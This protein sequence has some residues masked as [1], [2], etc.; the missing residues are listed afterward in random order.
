MS[1]R[2]IGKFRILIV[3]FSLAFCLTHT[4]CLEPCHGQLVDAIRNWF[5]DPLIHA[6]DKGLKPG[7]DLAWELSQL[8]QVTLATEAQGQAVL[9]ALASLS[10]DQGS[11]T[12][13]EN[14]VEYEV[15]NLFLY[16]W[17]VDS[18]AYI[19]LWRRG[20]PE[21]ISVYDKLRLRHD[22]ATRAGQPVDHE[23][24]DDL[25]VM[26]SVMAQFQTREGTDCVLEAAQSGLGATSYHW[27]SVLSQYDTEHP[28]SERLFSEF[29]K[30]LPQGEI[31]TQL[32]E[33]ANSNALNDA[34]FAHPFSSPAG[35]VRLKQWLSKD[36][37]STDVD[38]ELHEHARAVAI[39][40]AFVD[41]PERETVLEVAARHPDRL[42]RLEGAWAAARAGLDS[43]FQRLVEYT[44]D[45][46]SSFM[47]QAYLK[48]FDRGDLI[49]AEALEP[50]FAAM[51]ELSNWLQSEYEFGQAPDEMEV[52]DQRQLKWLPKEM[53][54][55]EDDNG[56]VEADLQ[57]DN[58]DASDKSD[59]TPSEDNVARISE[60]SLSNF[61]LL[62]VVRY[63]IAG[64]TPL[65]EDLTG[66]GLVGSPMTWSYSNDDLEQ[67]PVE[68]V[69]GAHYTLEAV[70]NGLIEELDWND[71]QQ[72]DPKLAESV[73]NQWTAQPPLTDLDV[74]EVYRLEKE[75]G[76]PQPRVYV[77]SARRADQPGYVVLA[78]EDSR[79]YPADQFPDQVATS[80]ILQLHIGRQLL[81]FPPAETRMLRPIPV[82]QIAPEKVVE[83]YRAWLD[84]LPAAQGERR[85]ELL[86]SYQTTLGTHFDKYVEALAKISNRG[87]D[88]IF[89]ETYQ[90]IL[91]EAQRGD[92]QE[93][94]EML[95]AS[96]AVGEKFEGYAAIIG[97]EHP[98]QVAQLIKLFE[99]RW[100]HD[101]GRSVLAR[102]AYKVGRRDEAKRILENQMASDSSGFFTS[103]DSRILAEIWHAEGQTD[104]ARELLK[105][106][107]ARG[108]AELTIAD[109]EEYKRD[110]LANIA[111]KKE[112]Y[113]KLFGQ[114]FEAS[115]TPNAVSDIELRRR[116]DFK[117]LKT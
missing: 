83:I 106:A 10:Q 71:L 105:D 103:E 35:L 61:S 91:A 107:I 28:Q 36:N 66:V 45:V 99:P 34:A 117:D 16:A 101:Y 46:H 11:S 84:E 72:Q 38:Y 24:V 51:S 69:Y 40:L 79:W 110:L 2:F 27:Y 33:V 4:I 60:S 59:N 64:P 58:S 80:T 94:D 81:G 109:Y 52:L 12:E 32:L 56:E 42:V 47:A 95:D 100:S 26:L 30:R 19:L 37:T 5:R 39:A 3:A 86:G 67:L 92:A 108:E 21:L 97:Q 41:L 70:T 88:A 87:K 116:P 17:D 18:P 63:R 73:S 29:R 53:Y 93:I 55:S 62:S 8:E 14:S 111:V 113:L 9:R 90:Y 25:V 102:V 96:A 112:S 115:S 44:Q 20:I 76:Y 114:P 13:S 89:V 43:G 50:K 49:P 65:D 68:D 82:K 31:A 7:G 15:A 23:R 1:P 48:E 6:V 75:L 57:I 22:Q 98:E 78:G 85:L 77:A 104:K 74:H 54:Y